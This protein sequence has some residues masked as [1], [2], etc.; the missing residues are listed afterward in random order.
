MYMGWD[1]ILHIYG[2]GTLPPTIIT[3]SSETNSIPLTGVLTFI[4]LISLVSPVLLSIIICEWFVMPDLL[5]WHHIV[6]HTVCNIV[7]SLCYGLNGC[8]SI[9]SVLRLCNGLL[10]AC[11]MLCH[12]VCVCCC[13]KGI[14]QPITYILAC[15][16]QHTIISH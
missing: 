16:H 9:G 8:L 11:G 15:P 13:G 1:L 14:N 12:V 3:S 4:D 6:K 5:S 7:Y 10:Y 2:T